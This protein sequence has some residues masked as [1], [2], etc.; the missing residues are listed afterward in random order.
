MVLT[1]DP[2]HWAPVVEERGAL[3]ARGEEAG[4]HEPPQ[5]V[6]LTLHALTPLPGRTRAQPLMGERQGEYWSFCAG[7]QGERRSRTGRPDAA[8][9]RRA[10]PAAA[11]CSRKNASRL[12]AA[13]LST[14]VLERT[15]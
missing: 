10:Q 6:V 4:G 3:E 8:T 1:A 15:L 5:S 2:A 14:R 7:A 13:R 11:Y 9:S 12:S